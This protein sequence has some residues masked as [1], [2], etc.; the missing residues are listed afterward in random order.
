MA[1]LETTPFL[2]LCPPLPL[3][4]VRHMTRTNCKEIRPPGLGRSLFLC[5]L[6]RTSAH[7]KD[8]HLYSQSDYLLLHQRHLQNKSEHGP[9][10]APRRPFAGLLSLNVRRRKHSQALVSSHT[11]SLAFFPNA[12]NEYRQV[13]SLSLSRRRVWY[14]SETVDAVVAIANDAATTL[15]VT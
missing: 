2:H 6:G 15:S 13:D 1:W 14:H 7:N 12:A 11:N 9:F 10:G 3:N 4:Q 8:E 5:L